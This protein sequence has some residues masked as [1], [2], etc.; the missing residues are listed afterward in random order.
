MIYKRANIKGGGLCGA[1]SQKV[2]KIEGSM[3]AS[4]ITQSPSVKHSYT[5][6][7]AC[8]RVCVCSSLCDGRGVGGDSGPQVGAFFGHW[9]RDGAALHLSFVVDDDTSVVLEVQSHSVFA[10]I[11]L[12]LTNH[13]GRDH[14]KI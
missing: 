8:A 2:L 10:M 9:S 14:L 13:H 1:R 11:R 12:S 3:S 7:R 4:G 6:V 5:R